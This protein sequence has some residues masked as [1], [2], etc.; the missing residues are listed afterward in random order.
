MLGAER[1]GINDH[2]L[3]T[4]WL[5]DTWRTRRELGDLEPVYRDRVAAAYTKVETCRLL[6]LRLKDIG[7]GEL[8][9]LVKMARNFAEQETAMTVMDLLGADAM[10]GG[11]Y[12][13]LD[14]GV[15]QNGAMRFLRTRAST[16]SGG[17]VEIMRNILGER[18]LG[19]PGDVRVD[20]DVPWSQVPRS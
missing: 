5:L 2:A 3:P 7:A 16:I 4:P 13:W 19:L 10:V 17:S 14:R 8:I 18:V 20:K 15:E 9:P 1:E 6:G 12:D 11:E